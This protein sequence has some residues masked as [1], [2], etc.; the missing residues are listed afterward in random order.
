MNREFHQWHS[1]RLGRDMEMLV[2]G[3]GGTP[4][5]VF[6]TSKGRFFE[7][8]DRGMVQ[9]LSWHLD[10]GWIQLFC[11]DSIDSDSW[12]NY[13]AHPAHRAWMHSLYDG[14]IRNEV[15]P[16]IQ[17]KNTNPYLITT[18]CSFGG[19]HAVNF[20]FRYPDVVKKVVSLGGIFSIRDYIMGWFDDNCYF[21]CP[22][23]FLPGVSG[24][25]LEGLKQQS[26]ILAAGE[27]DICRGYNE[28]FV[29]QIYEKGIWYTFDLYPG[30][31]HDW[32]W[33][34]A[35]IQKYLAI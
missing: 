2:F 23:D 22:T 34:Q 1:S 3:H 19:Y 14:Y 17:Y 33:W 9:A 32:P 21:N 30:A 4:V 20:A 12:Y 29:H 11:V 31:G 24:A 10:Q 16:F 5:I 25:Q 28:A 13:S 35:W 6:P 15:V 8:E 26:I 7:Y 18:G 27:H